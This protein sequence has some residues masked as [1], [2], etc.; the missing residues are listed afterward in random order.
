MTTVTRIIT[1]AGPT[2]MGRRWSSEAGVG[3]VVMV[4]A[5]AGAMADFAEE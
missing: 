2:I 5:G 4:M 3:A 1:P